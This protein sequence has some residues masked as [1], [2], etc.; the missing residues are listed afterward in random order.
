MEEIGSSSSMESKKN[1]RV[2]GIDL[3]TTYS[4]VGFWIGEE[5]RI[6]KIPSCI[7]F[8]ENGEPVVGNE[9]LAGVDENPSNTILDVKLLD[10]KR[11]IGV[12]FSDNDTQLDILRSSIE[13]IEDPV[14]KNDEP[15][16]IVGS[17]DGWMRFSAEELLCMI[18]KK[19]KQIGEEG[20]GL[21]NGD[22][23][24]KAVISVP[25]CYN[26]AQ[27]LATKR[28]ATMA[29]F[30]DSRLINET[31]ATALA[32]GWLKKMKSRQDQQQ[33]GVEARI[34]QEDEENV[35]IFDLGG[36]TLSV[37]VVNI[38]D[39]WNTYNV[40][41]VAGDTHLGGKDFTDEL[42]LYCS[43]KF[44]EIQTLLGARSKSRLRF[45]C[46]DA[47]RILDYPH[48]KQTVVSVDSYYVLSSNFT[49]R[50]IAIPLSVTVTKDEFAEKCQE[51]FDKCEE[52]VDQCVQISGIC[53]FHEII[54]VGGST[55]ISRIREMLR[56]F[57][58]HAQG[59]C[60]ILE[61]D[62]AVVQGAAIQAAIWSG[63][64]LS[65]PLLNGISIT[66]VA[67][68]TLSTKTAQY[69]IL[70][71][72]AS[73]NSLIAAWNN[74]PMVGFSTRKVT[75]LCRSTLKLPNFIPRNTKIPTVRRHPFTPARDTRRFSA[76]VYE[77]EDSKMK[78]NNLIGH[79][80]F[81]GIQ[82]TEMGLPSITVSFAVDR[83]GILNVSASQVAEDGSRIRQLARQV[84]NRSLTPDEL[85]Q[86]G[87]DME[88]PEPEEI[89]RKKLEAKMK[90]WLFVNKHMLI[91]LLPVL[92]PSQAKILKEAI[93]D[94]QA[95]LKNSELPEVRAS[96]LKLD[97][98]Q[99]TCFLI[100][101]RRRGSN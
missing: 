56:E 12:K 88:N 32:Y 59:F 55:R 51:L 31:T 65:N 58:R 86:F 18:L 1:V 3:G 24:V 99:A 27:R 82:A 77:G 50:K 64:A 68:L 80:I 43:D 93:E 52:S 57:C 30:E 74:L 70:S 89:K 67:P 87:R 6:R 47:K 28:A 63:E 35:L 100:L 101:R 46:E 36:G 13:V 44:E 39:G 48:A 79:F 11:L 97:E 73:N 22:V 72:E 61:P 49:N 69:V 90:V 98:L 96:E 85:N 29:G 45:A 15:N 75:N 76:G 95:W 94:A 38:K 19:L 91:Q 81:D 25:S 2:I 83:D 54:L 21:D 66:D 7:T 26:N 23:V 5:L 16:I 8:A 40:E 4:R 17:P 34:P 84:I 33:H 20:L 41:S 78:N 60:E 62:A 42:S 53:R 37:A 14:S 71:G 92:S 9:A 10:V